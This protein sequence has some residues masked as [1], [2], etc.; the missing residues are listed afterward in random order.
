MAHVSV[1]VRDC[2]QESGAACVK[3]TPLFRSW[4]VGIDG[5]WDRASNSRVGN[6][7]AGCVRLGRRL[8]AVRVLRLS[9]V[10]GFLRNEDYAFICEQREIIRAWLSIERPV[11]GEWLLRRSNFEPVLDALLSGCGPAFRTASGSYCFFCS[12]LSTNRIRCTVWS[13]SA[14]RRSMRVLPVTDVSC[15]A[16]DLATPPVFAGGS[17]SQP[18]VVPRPV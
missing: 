3:V 18:P 11:M 14:R 12:S 15:R 16:E 4:R 2:K 8:T 6:R 7:A 17:S 1:L 13:W 10:V 5:C 9:P